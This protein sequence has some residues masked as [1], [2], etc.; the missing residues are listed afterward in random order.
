MQGRRTLS[1][2][3][4]VAAVFA[5]M[6]VYASLYPFTGW[7]FQGMAPWAFVAAPWPRYWTGFDVLA[8]LVG[9]APL[10][11]LLALAAVR[12]GWSRWAMVWGGAV[13]AVLSL[14][15]ESVQA[16]LPDRV[17]SNLDW[18]L[19]SLGALAGAGV[20]GGLL[21]WHVLRPWNQFREQW[22]VP[23]AHGGVLLLLLWPWA[24]L[25]P[26]SVPFGLGQVWQRLEW[27]AVEAL[28]GSSF[29]HWLPVPGGLTALSPLT[30]A[31]VLALCVWAPV[32][33]GNALLRHGW[34]R[35]V[36]GAVFFGLV[37][38]VGALSAALTY[39]PEH[40]WAWL[41]PPVRLGL[42]LAAG[43]SV[44][45]GWLGRRVCAVLMLLAWCVAL[46]VLNQA[47]DTAYLAQ[48]LQTWEQGAFIRFHGLSQWLGWL[49]PYAALWVG[50]RLVL[51]PPVVRGAHYNPTA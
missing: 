22:L 5:A 12:T 8:N 42:V 9:Y 23:Q 26:S 17:P 45:S 10:G 35:P 1:L 11:F 31:A 30:E 16:F 2:A 14:A 34:Q 3:W 41:T 25:Y 49:W 28:E 7:R 40:V 47:P 33:L 4:L 18:A 27:L 50:V 21:P 37:A 36:F 43:L 44:L 13:P 6:V 15:L 29:A 24:V 32:L 48:S 19:N 39:G 38:G 46:G 51:Q 20:A